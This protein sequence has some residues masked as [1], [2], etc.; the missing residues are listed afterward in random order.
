MRLIN[1][2]AMLNEFVV[3]KLNN[4]KGSGVI[5]GLL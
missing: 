4:S 5:V 3:F 2:L 1:C